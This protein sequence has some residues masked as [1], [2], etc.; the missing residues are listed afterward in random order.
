[1]EELPR[2]LIVEDEPAIA[3]TLIY[4]LKTEGFAPEWCATGRAGLA[5]LE[6]KPF[7]LVVLDVGVPDGSGFDVCKQIRVHRA[8]PVD[9][10][11][12]AAL[13]PGIIVEAAV[14]AAT[15]AAA[16]QVRPLPAH[17]QAAAADHIT[18][19]RTKSM[20]QQWEQVKGLL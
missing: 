6:A 3:D 13:T 9:L 4:A 19:E 7:A 2:I 18:Q 12:V 1:M 8:V 16:A 17:K 15:A 14:V 5:A 11:A 20:F 10:A